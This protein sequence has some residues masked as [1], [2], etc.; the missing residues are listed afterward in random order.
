MHITFCSSQREGIGT[1]FPLAVRLGTSVWPKAIA[2]LHEHF[3]AVSDFL[4][5]SNIFNCD[6]Y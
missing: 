1:E 5:F 6:Q 4:V 2:E 3:R